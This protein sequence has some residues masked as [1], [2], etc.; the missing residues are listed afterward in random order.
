M[1][2]YYVTTPIYYVNDKP[3]IGHAYTNVLADT[4]ARYHRF[5]GEDVFFLT[6]TD[7]HGEKIYKTAKQKGV[8]VKEY[9]DGVV[10]SFKELWKKMGVTY[11]YFIRTTDEKHK[12][13]VQDIIS[14]LIEKEDI[15]QSKYKGWY[16]TPCE[17]FWTEAQLDEGKCPD[18]KREVQELEEDNY[19]FALSRYQEWLVNYIKENEGFIL[20]EIRR[21]EVLSFLKEPLQDLCISRPRER[22]HWGVHFP[23]T[24]DHVVYV[25]FDALINYLSAIKFETDIE[26]NFTE[27]WPADLQ[28]IGKDILRQHAVYWPIMLKAL[29]VRMPKTVFAHGWWTMGGA[30]VSKSKGN[31]VSPQEIIDKYGT[32]TLRYYLLHEVKMGLDGAYSEELVAERFNSDLANALGNLVH[33]SFSMLEKYRGGEVPRCAKEEKDGIRDKCVKLAAE[34]DK[35][36]AAFDPRE[37]LDEIWELI[38]DANRFIEDTKP[39]ILAKSEEKSGELDT[40]LYTLFEALRFIGVA[41]VPFLPDTSGNILKLLKTESSFESLSQ[42]GALKSGS[43]LAKGKPLF[44]KI[45]E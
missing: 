39:W 36:M 24:E 5:K 22:L 34:I 23:G 2:K 35:S 43:K 1:K 6:G 15:Y 42:W 27:Y 41:L 32:D 44:P 13:T 12:K 26:T 18:C 16:C 17:T 20:P 14:K 8:D 9:I 7:E 10:P 4:F 30:K 45:E 40:F 3:H 11:D 31:I 19:F 29:D 28:I 25:W 33:R 37:A 21:K 38:N